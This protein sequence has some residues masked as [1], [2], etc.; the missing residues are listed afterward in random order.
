MGLLT[1][2]VQLGEFRGWLGKIW[3]VLSISAD[4]AIGDS[5]EQKVCVAASSFRGLALY[6]SISTAI[7]AP[8]VSPGRDAYLLI[9][10]QLLQRC[11]SQ[12]VWSC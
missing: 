10:L 6:N 7:A 1:G 8:A 2:G 12:I 3:A 9:L 4:M 5:A 11:A